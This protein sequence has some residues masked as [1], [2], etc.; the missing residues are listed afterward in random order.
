MLCERW[1]LLVSPD[2]RRQ[3]GQAKACES[4]RQA[5]ADL[6]IGLNAL[7]CSVTLA[8]PLK[9]F[10]EVSR[11]RVPERAGQALGS[12][13]AGPLVE[14]QIAGDD[15]GACTKLASLCGR[16]NAKKWIFRSTPPIST[17]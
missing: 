1:T 10:I 17:R 6:G 5:A 16:S 14:R 11:G 2:D 4:W 9:N 12:E 13:H 8:D 7:N 3:T 15:G